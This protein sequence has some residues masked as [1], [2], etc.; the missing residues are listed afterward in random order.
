MSE[1]RSGTQKHGNG[2]AEGGGQVSHIMIMAKNA[3]V[4]KSE[5]EVPTKHP[6]DISTKP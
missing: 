2:Q 5:G 3:G 1:E 6:C 4:W